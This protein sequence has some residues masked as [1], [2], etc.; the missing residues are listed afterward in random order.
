MV[1]INPVRVAGT[2]VDSNKGSINNRLDCA[3]EHIKNNTKSFLY[4]TAVA[5]SAAGA[6][7]TAGR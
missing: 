2:F 1:M 4:G 7:R 6:A 5:G 3:G